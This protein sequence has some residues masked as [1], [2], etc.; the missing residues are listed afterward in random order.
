[1]NDTFGQHGGT[2]AERVEALL[3]EREDPGLCSV[4]WPLAPNRTVYVTGTPKFCIE[5]LY[6]LRVAESADQDRRFAG[7][8][9]PNPP[10]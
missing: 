9:P 5:A 2:F 1:M 3:E 8:A 7:A 10:D 6:R 4:S